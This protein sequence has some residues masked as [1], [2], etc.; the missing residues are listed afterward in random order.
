MWND[1][2]MARPDLPPGMGG[3]QAIDGTPQEES[4]GMGIFSKFFF[5]MQTIYLFRVGANQEKLELLAFLENLGKSPSTQGSRE[6]L[7][8]GV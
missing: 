5:A 4:R 1:V 3:W 6:N 2:W 7:G 8:L